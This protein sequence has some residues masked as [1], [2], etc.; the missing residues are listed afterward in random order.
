MVFVA[1][2]IVSGF[3]QL[4]ACYTGLTIIPTADVL[5]HGEYGL[6][7]QFDGTFAAVGENTQVFDMEFG[8]LPRLEAGADFDLAR[9]SDSRVLLNAKYLI[10]EGGKHRPAL[11]LGTC[12][13]GTNA[14]SVPYLVATRGFDA[15][16][17]H[18]GIMR[19]EGRD[20]WFV[21]SDFALNERLMLM[22]D[23]VSGSENTSS[24]G[25]SY[26][27]NDRFGVLA[28]VVFPN[29]RGTSTGFTLH[30]VLNGPFSGSTKGQ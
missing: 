22:A 20:R 21:G 12:N 26:Q 13:V 14:R 25:A 27:V 16:R 8:L 1:V 11:A 7:Q 23:Y 6:E 9:D 18:L 28:G 4:D 5:D 17:G 19:M 29:E 3:T 15:L 2:L 30:L 24:V 10:S